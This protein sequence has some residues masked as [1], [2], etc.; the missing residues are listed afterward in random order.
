MV[1]APRQ[2]NYGILPIPF[3]IAR[4]HLPAQKD[5]QLTKTERPD[6]LK[7]EY[8]DWKEA[9]HDFLDNR[10]RREQRAFYDSLNL[11]ER[12]K[13]I[14]SLNPTLKSL[15]LDAVI[16]ARTG[17]TEKLAECLTNGVSPNLQGLMKLAVTGGQLGAVELLLARG[18]NPNKPVDGVGHTYLHEA[19]LQNHTAI[20][21]LLLAKGA[22]PNKKT[23]TGR[24]PLDFALERKH[25]RAAVV[26]LLQPVTPGP[27][28]RITYRVDDF[29][30]MEEPEKAYYALCAAMKGPASPAELRVLSLSSFIGFCWPNGFDDMFWRATWA[31]VPC[32]EL[33]EAIDEPGFAAMLRQ[34]IAIVTEYGQKIGRDP[35][36][37][38]DGS[39]ELDEEAQNKLYSPDLV[40]HKHD[41]DSEAL[42][43][44]T[45]DYVRKNRELF[46]SSS[47]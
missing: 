14:T 2:P 44:K 15:E 40:F 32:A 20:V 26:Q 11:V 33:M 1:H 22:D 18:A 41:Y 17:Q 45:M 3:A 46:I 8:P 25:E 38:D 39:L 21:E 4:P 27:K 36:D 16:F 43:R 6:W 35:F 10:I 34:C 7:K 30:A 5:E 42:Y 9:M 28:R 12:M 37:N 31:V 24:K 19:A 23:K 29:L 13:V 47:D